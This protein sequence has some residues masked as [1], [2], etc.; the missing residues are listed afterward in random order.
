M[1]MPDSS[2]MLVSLYSGAVLSL[3]ACICLM[4]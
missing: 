3:Y 4:N 1:L 2:P